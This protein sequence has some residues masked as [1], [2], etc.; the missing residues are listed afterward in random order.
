MLCVGLQ[1]AK[2]STGERPRSRNGLALEE[3]L[4]GTERENIESCHV[5]L[6]R[7]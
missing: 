6:A 2:E 3:T 5:G 1:A 4:E 7:L